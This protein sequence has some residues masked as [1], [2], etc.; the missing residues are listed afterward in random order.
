MSFNS[1]VKE[2]ILTK[3]NIALSRERRAF[4]SSIFRMSGSIEITRNARW[5]R[6]EIE[7]PM[8]LM[9]VNKM[10]EEEFHR[11]L[12]FDIK[13]EENRQDKYYV[14]KLDYDESIL[15]DTGVLEREGDSVVFTS[16]I[17]LDVSGRSEIT[18]YILGCF[19]SRGGVY[20]PSEKKHSGYHL[21]IAFRE[22][23]IAS[24][25]ACMLAEFDIFMKK[26][27]RGDEYI[28]YIKE[29]DMIC[30]LL[31]I[32]GAKECYFELQNLI[33]LRS[34]K[35]NANRHGNCSVANAIK[36][37]DTSIKHIMA[38]NYIKEHGAYETLNKKL[39]DVA[40]L[41]LDNPNMPLEELASMLTPPITKS[42]INHRLTKILNIADELRKE[43]GDE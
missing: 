14:A 33:I 19:L 2:E 30:D 32:L 26:V 27:E 37:A 34:Q 17:G 21:E 42:G 6:L 8:L 43:N 13:N 38:I 28:L 29:S 10:F 25:L 16:G 41:R 5:F 12:S 18:A 7:D 20:V 3:L 4:I 39:K 23:E 24:E 9:Y 40:E 1:K 36:V 15:I 22:D 31:M 35:N 11:S